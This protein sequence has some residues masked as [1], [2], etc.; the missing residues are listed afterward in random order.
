[1]I[2]TI[3]NIKFINFY[4]FN[5]NQKDYNLAYSNHDEEELQKKKSKEIQQKNINIIKE[6]F[7]LESIDLYKSSIIPH[8]LILMIIER[9]QNLQDII[10]H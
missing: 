9:F 3:N 6:I 8:D 4:N 2:K 10:I 5:I 7:I 1:M